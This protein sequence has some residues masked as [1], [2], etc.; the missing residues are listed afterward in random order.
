MDLTF[1]LLILFAIYPLG[2]R[3]TRTGRQG[4]NRKREQLTR[5]LPFSLN[6]TYILNR[7]FFFDTWNIQSESFRF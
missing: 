3:E 7:Y 1:I 6:L 5:P 2:I 4:I